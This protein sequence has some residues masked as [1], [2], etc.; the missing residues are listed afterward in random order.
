MLATIRYKSKELSIDPSGN[1]RHPPE[2]R[3][4]VMINE[5]VKHTRSNSTS[6]GDT[7]D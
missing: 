1:F 5:A 4:R 7:V 3:P 2:S 6:L